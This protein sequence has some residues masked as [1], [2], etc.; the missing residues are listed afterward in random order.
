[1]DGNANNL[2]LISR[3]YVD[4]LIGQQ[5]YDTGLLAAETLHTAVTKGWDAIRNNITRTRLISYNLVPDDL[6]PH[7]VDQHLL[8]NLKY[9][10]ILCFCI[11][12]VLSI[13]F[14]G[15]T[16]FNRSSRVIKASQ[17]FFLVMIAFGVLTLASALIPLSFDDDGS[18][19]MISDSKAV[20]I[21]MSIPWLAF[22]GFAIIFSALFAK[23]WRVNKLFSL[24]KTGGRIQVSEKDVIAP[25]AVVIVLNN[26]VLILWTVLDPLTYER[27][28][29]LG[30]DLWN[31]DLAS[32]GFCQSE[33]EAAYL[34]PLGL[35]KFCY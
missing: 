31:R 16:V 8:E 32:K 27:N 30:T 18:S 19:D 4:G 20:G 6:P 9:V 1:M 33:N 29:E 2:K 21:C 14:I 3:G 25:A 34:I 15:W 10:G 22:N 23:T 26:I 24:S 5:T 12:G 11:V 7:Q 13:Y 28:F 35:S 17:P